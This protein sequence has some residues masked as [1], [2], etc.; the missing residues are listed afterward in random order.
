MDATKFLDLLPESLIDEAEKWLSEGER[1]A[2]DA[3]G[4]LIMASVQIQLAQAM[5]LIAIAKSLAA[6][7]GE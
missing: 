5:A 7:G 6:K 4:S 3:S 1:T 2:L